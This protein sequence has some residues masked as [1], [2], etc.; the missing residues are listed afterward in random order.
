M[1]T[2][3]YLTEVL[4]HIRFI[5]RSNRDPVSCKQIRLLKSFI[6]V[7]KIGKYNYDKYRWHH[8]TTQSS[9]LDYVT[10]T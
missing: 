10:T 7:L 3:E 4:N 1:K 8:A 9:K 2:I 5:E 6:N